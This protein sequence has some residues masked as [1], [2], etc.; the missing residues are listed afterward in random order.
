M[1]DLKSGMMAHYD[2][3]DALEKSRRLN[4]HQARTLTA[5]FRAWTHQHAAKFG[6]MEFDAARSCVAAYLGGGGIADEWWSTMS[7]RSP[8]LTKVKL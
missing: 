5:S 2:N 1:S 8:L 3:V 7:H 4:R 6:L